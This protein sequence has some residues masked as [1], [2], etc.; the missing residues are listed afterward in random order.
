MRHN[1]FCSKGLFKLFCC[2]GGSLFDYSGKKALHKYSAQFEGGR[3]AIEVFKEGLVLHKSGRNVAVRLNY[4][5]TLEQTSAEP[6]SKV[7]VKLTYYDMFGNL[8]SVSFQIRETDFKALK[9]DLGKQ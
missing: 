8:E 6:L 5:Q 7:G 9:M 1:H 4:V 3:G 2:W